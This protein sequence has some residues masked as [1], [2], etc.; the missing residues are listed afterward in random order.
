M[1][2]F[3]LKIF[4]EKFFFFEFFFLSFRE[5]IQNLESGTEI[6]HKKKERKDWKILNPEFRKREIFVG[7]SLHQKSYQKD[8]KKIF[9][10][11][12]LRIQ[13]LI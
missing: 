11:Q 12:M 4:F 2:F 9:Q 8:N 7:K 5:K 13:I 3:F 6:Q 1:G 10:N